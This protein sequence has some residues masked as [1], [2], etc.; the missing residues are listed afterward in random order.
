[1]PSLYDK[2]VDAFVKF[3]VLTVIALVFVLVVAFLL[4]AIAAVIGL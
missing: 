3:A 4:N 2:V 1:M